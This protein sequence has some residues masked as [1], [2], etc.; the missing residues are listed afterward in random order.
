MKEL[1]QTDFDHNGSAFPHAG[2]AGAGD[3]RVEVEHVGEMMGSPWDD[4]EGLAPA[5]AC[6][7]NLHRMDYLETFGD[8]DVDGEG[9][10]FAALAEADGDALAQVFGIDTAGELVDVHHASADADTLGQTVKDV[11]DA[12]VDAL[13][14][15]AGTKRL[16]V[17]EQL[18]G[19]AGIECEL[20]HVYG[21][22]QS[23]YAEVLAVFLPEWAEKVGALASD[24]ARSVADSAA[25]FADYFRGD[26]FGFAIEDRNGNVVDSCAGFYGEDWEGNGLLEC[27]NESLAI[28]SKS[29]H[30]DQAAAIAVEARAYV[31]T[32]RN[33]F[34]L[35][36]QEALNAVE[37]IVKGGIE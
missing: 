27:V 34:G 30:D 17:L 19:M 13:Y 3:F 5:I 18:Y 26:M 16:E 23:D 35:E 21:Y 32:V 1:V 10:D 6:Y 29:G 11:A 12:A 36:S 9:I 33:K 28:L 25:R 7:P 8:I 15:V 22:S 37:A 20:R 14:D 31:C 4:D 24:A 2:E